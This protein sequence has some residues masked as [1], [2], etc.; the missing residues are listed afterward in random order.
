MSNK[1]SLSILIFIFNTSFFLHKSPQERTIL[2]E[3]NVNKFVKRGFTSI[4]HTAH[5]TRVL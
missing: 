5:Y 4:K 1:I 3:T 2:D